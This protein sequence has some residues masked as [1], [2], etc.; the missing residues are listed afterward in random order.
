MGG[1]LRAKGVDIRSSI[2]FM[3]LIARSKEMSEA[4]QSEAVRD[5]VQRRLDDED[6]EQTAAS[7][8][9]EHL[10]A[11]S[12]VAE[13]ENAK[14]RLMGATDGHP[15]GILNVGIFGEGVDAPALSA[16]GFLEARKSPVDVIQAVG[17]VMRRAENKQ[18][19]YIICPILIP[20][21]VDAETWL[22][23][24]GPEDGWRELGQILLALRAHDG[25]IEDQLSELMQLYLPPPPKDDVAT[26]VSLGD[27]KDHRTRHYGHVGKPGTAET[28]VQEVLVGKAQ[29]GKVFCPLKEVMPTADP[30]AAESPG[31]HAA[32]SPG[33]PVSGLVEERI[34]SGMRGADG[35]SS[36]SPAPGLVA[37]RIVSGKR[38]ADGSVELREAGTVRA[39]PAA[40]GTPGPVDVDKSKKLGRKM[41]NGEEGRKIDRQKRAE[42]RKAREEARIR[43]LFDEVDSVNLLAQ[44]GLARDRAER[45]VNILEDS[46]DEARRCLKGD[47]LDGVL[48]RHFG[49]DQLAEDKRKAQ[50]DGCTIASLLLM[51]AA[52]LHQR[53][54]AGGWLP[55]ISGMDRIKNAP[56]AIMEVY[57]QWNRITRHDFLPVVEPAIEVID[58]LQQYGRRTGL[59]RALRHLAGEA[60]RIAA[61][62]ADLGA[63]H[64]GP[65][66]NKV[67][68]NQAS[69]GAFFTRPPA[70]ALLARL[71]L[72]AAAG[73]DADWTAEATWREHRTVDL[74]C[75]SGTLIAAVL[76]DMKR[77]AEELGASSQRLAK[78]Q[79]LAVEEIIAGLDFNAVSLQLAAAQLTA[80]NRDVAYRKIGLHRMPYGPVDGRA[81]VGTPELL[82]QRGILRSAG[83]D[84]GDEALGSQ[85]VQM[86]RDDPLLEN[87]ID[88][89]RSVRIVIMNPPFSNRSRMGEKFSKEDQG[90]MRQRVDSYER[91][92]VAADPE[93]EGFIDKNSIGLIFEALADK[94]L[95]QAN[96]VLA[97]I[98]PT[99]A[100]TGTSN[101]SRRRILAGRFHIHTL[102]TCHQ[103]GQVNLSQHTAIN[104]S[105]II[106]KRHEGARP[107]TRIVNLD[108]FPSDEGE[109]AE[110]HQHL[111]N[112]TT[113][114][115]PDGW[116]EV[117]AW[118]A[119]HIE[120]GNWSAAAFRS[121]ELAETAVQIA[122][123]RQLLSIIDQEAVPSAVLQGGGRGLTKASADTSGSFPVLYSKGAEAQLR[124]QAMPDLYMV[125][126][127]QTKVGVLL[128][129]QEHNHKEQLLKHAGHLLVTNGQNTSTARLTAVASDSQ[130]I[131]VGWMPVP[132]ITPAQAKAAA[133]FLNSTAGRLQFMQNPGASLGYPKYNPGA[134][135]NIRIPNLADERTMSVLSA[136][137]EQTRE[138]EVPQFRDGECEVRR[139]WDEA[140][141]KVLDWDPERL[142]KLRQL[143]HDEPHVRGLGREQYGE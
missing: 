81:R 78:L 29:T 99:I 84:L 95:D 66:F 61:S 53:I 107:P 35:S 94:C 121:P 115:L 44:S 9:L 71:T 10:D 5:W 57:K 16:V 48:D 22:R 4:L 49:L 25:R 72:D 83:F 38:L 28:A 18:M 102:L 127:K 55:E 92:L 31:P 87:A 2:N 116:G 77:R 136:C 90:K 100:L 23:N 43:G 112:C 139:L 47:E 109:A 89:A 85:Q 117:S 120:A 88:A 140:V 50:A 114:P 40:D 111:A 39:K 86:D 131:G 26:M 27:D 60:E 41:V 24:S 64:A 123:D 7:Y 125:S 106:L 113:G 124:I 32:K 101:K 6:A 138:M 65:L 126:T 105:M 46:I 133:V 45:D 30:H 3:N 33:S 132:G 141:A 129:G 51:N 122:Q 97:M 67:M 73:Q 104:E 75:G 80:G 76:T 110:L 36:A 34:V 12:K 69:D 17:R 52:M 128:D 68:G 63:D 21:N 143:L 134:Y 59:N 118:P 91:T 119:S 93:M 137:W 62:Y 1:A 56:D 15:H 8:Q 79:R 96:G 142:S 20:P 42:E 14:A 13:R 19:G 54:A 70:A 130:Y 82:G 58:A 103:P 11:S 135:E 74:A 98:S 108:R 37:E